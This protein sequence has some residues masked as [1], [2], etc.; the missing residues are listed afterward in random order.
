MNASLDKIRYFIILICLILSIVQYGQVKLK[1][2]DRALKAFRNQNYISALEEF[3]KLD[4]YQKFAFEVGVCYFQTKELEKAHYWLSEYTKTKNINAEVYY[5]LGK[6]YQFQNA[7]EKAVLNYKLFLRFDKN[8]NSNLRIKVKNDIKRCAT[9][10]YVIR[11]DVLGY[12]EQ[13]PNTINTPYHEIGPVFSINFPDRI[14]FSSNHP[15]GDNSAHSNM[16]GVEIQQG[17]W[18]RVFS[19][20]EKLNTKLQEVLIDFSKDGQ[21][22]YYYQGNADNAFIMVD[23]L[24]NSQKGTLSQGQLKCPVDLIKGDHYLQILENRIIFS[25]IRDGGFGGYDLYLTSLVDNEWTTPINLGSKVNT[26]FDEVAPFLAKN[27][28]TLYFSSNRTTSIGGFDIFET[29]YTPQIGWGKPKNLGLPVNSA[30]DELYFRLSESG[31]NA[32]FS[33]N[34]NGIDQGYDL[35]FTI[36]KQPVTSMLKVQPEIRFWDETELFDGFSNTHKKQ[37]ELLN[38]PFLLYEVNKLILNPY[39]INQ[40]SDLIDALKKH[41]N[42]K[43]DVIGH[44]DD[45]DK[46]EYNLFFSAKRAEEVATYFVQ[47]GIEASRIFIVGT[48]SGYPIALNKVNGIANPSGHRF[49]R[50]IEFVVH[51]DI[52]DRGEFNYEAPVI[53]SHFKDASYAV[54]DSLTL[55]LSYKIFLQMSSRPY[56]P[57]S[58]QNVNGIMIEKHYLDSSYNYT[59]EIVKTFFEANQ[60]KRKYREKGFEDAR[61]LAYINGRRIENKDIPKYSEKYPDLVYYRYRSE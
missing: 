57:E 34:R 47:Q 11:Q 49:N 18:S 31:R 61:V 13:L 15:D 24:A 4:V 1:S 23:T 41:T 44:S 29:S 52:Q 16:Y 33:S 58:L 32:A 40:T 22:A 39:N 28:T 5:W 35:F 21:L 17:Q 45:R 51:D 42:W 37:V 59:A 54:Y 48:G 56:L 50:R 43:I 46:R 7:F 6:V 53:V 55:G 20:N 30:G 8:G 60:L 3:Q 2:A 38:I 26:A 12:L 36:F 10:S 27:E 14:Y 25:S 9:G 19:M